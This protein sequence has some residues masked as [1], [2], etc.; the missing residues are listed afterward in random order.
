MAN[1]QSLIK[2]NDI[3]NRIFTIRGL[4]IMLDSHLAELYNVETKYLNKVVKRNDDR[5]PIDFMFQLTDEEWESLRF[6]FG[7]SNNLRFQIGTSN[8]E[9]GGRRYLP[10]VFTEQGVAMLSAVLKSET[11]VK[12]SIQIIQTFVELR[13][14]Y[15]ANATIFQRL[16][17]IEN[18]MMVADEKFEQI[19][20]AMENKT[21][22]PTQGI[23][24]D[25]EMFDAYTFVADL[26]RKAK[27]S[28][29]LIDNYVDDTVLYLF[30]KRKKGV[31]LTIY[32][33]IISKQ[34]TQDVNKFNSQYEPLK[35]KEL[36]E[37]HDR[38]L[39]LDEKELYHIGAS[40]K[41]LGKKWFAFSKM[42]AEVLNLLNKLKE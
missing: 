1:K 3:E 19:F 38:F 6:Q 11:A 37:A 21:S 42:D 26:I 22:L 32:T 20:N 25:G 13:K 9:R 7:T 31:K 29:I 2:Q 14:F 28:I 41:D 40:L 5:F 23:F 35:I 24:F 4:Q 10:F 33:K 36:K 30:T 27:T 15:I 17:K 8:S 12:V 16:D 34:L 39:I 18:K